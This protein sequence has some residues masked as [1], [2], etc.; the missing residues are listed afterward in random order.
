MYSII[1]TLTGFTVYNAFGSMMHL[2]KQGEVIYCNLVQDAPG[3]RAMVEF[4]KASK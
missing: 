2:N 3:Y 1:K 4:F